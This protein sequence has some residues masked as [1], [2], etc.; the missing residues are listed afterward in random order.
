MAF[1]NFVLQRNA[2]CIKASNNSI[3]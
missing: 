2:C 3:S 1:D